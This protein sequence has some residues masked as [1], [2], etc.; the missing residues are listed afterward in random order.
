MM[1]ER[2]LPGAGTTQ[3]LNLLFLTVQSVRYVVSD[4]RRNGAEKT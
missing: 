3:Y 2:T 1:N 4:V